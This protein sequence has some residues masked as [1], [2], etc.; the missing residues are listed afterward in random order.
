MPIAS[1]SVAQVHFATLPDGP[2]TVY[3]LAVRADGSL[4]AVPAADDT[5]RWEIGA[6]FG[7]E[8]VKVIASKTPI[9]PLDDPALKQGRFNPVSARQI[10]GVGALLNK[11]EA[12]EWAEDVVEIATASKKEPP[13]PVAGRRIG[14]FFGTS[15]YKFD[16]EEK[17]GTEGKGKLNLPC[18]ANGAKTLAR[19][20]Q[21]FGR[22]DEVK[23]F[24]DEQC[25]KRQI[26]H[27]I[28]Q[29]LPSVTKPG[30]TVI[31]E[32]AGEIIP[33]VIRVLEEMRPPNT[34]P[35]SPRA[36]F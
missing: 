5:F 34:P 26:E 6:P 11:A 30:D 13:P 25:T 32:K 2:S 23:V 27:T 12:A 20:M 14:V 19:L 21:D 17:E 28:T 22:L 31:I 9:K 18:C 1:A 8:S 24:T 15:V 16:A 3:G 33:Q 36:A 4:V 10:G 35:M 29:W 7:K